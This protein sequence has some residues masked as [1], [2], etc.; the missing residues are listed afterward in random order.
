VAVEQ[1]CQAGGGVECANAIAATEL[2]F[3]AAQLV[4]RQTLHKDT[5]L[6]ASEVLAPPRAATGRAG[7]I[8]K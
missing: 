2:E 5:G 3:E 1:L 6:P 8:A 4:G 7:G